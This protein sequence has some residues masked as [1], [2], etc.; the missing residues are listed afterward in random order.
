MRLAVEAFEE[1]VEGFG[2]DSG[3]DV[4]GEGGF[5]VGVAEGAF[6]L[7]LFQIGRAHV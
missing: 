1:F 4:G 3:G 2:A 7:Y 5:L 6:L